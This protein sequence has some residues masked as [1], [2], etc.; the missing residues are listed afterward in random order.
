MNSVPYF[1][2]KFIYLDG[3]RVRVTPDAQ[4]M[5]EKL[6]TPIRR[7]DF[8]EGTLLKERFTSY[9]DLMIDYMKDTTCLH[10]DH[11]L[12]I[13]HNIPPMSSYAAL[14]YIHCMFANMVAFRKLW[15]ER[16]S[17]NI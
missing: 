17:V 5:F 14:S 9:K 13:R 4:R 7:R 16:F 3:G 8:E 2:S 10:V 11:L 1:C 6:S 15:D 12:S